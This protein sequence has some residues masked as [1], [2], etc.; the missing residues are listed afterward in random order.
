MALLKML[1][2]R[3][4]LTL[5]NL[6]ELSSELLSDEIELDLLELVELEDREDERLDSLEMLFESNEDCS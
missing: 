1:G 2:V 6:T 5:E 4:V 3:S